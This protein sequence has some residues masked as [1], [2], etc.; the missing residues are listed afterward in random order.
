MTPP[1]LTR[2]V[3]SDGAP[4]RNP[5]PCS[6]T[7]TGSG[8]PPGFPGATTSSFRQSSSADPGPRP[9]GCGHGLPGS[10]ARSVDVQPACGT[11]GAHRRS[12]RGAAAY[13]MPRQARTPSPAVPHTA[14]LSVWTVVPSAQAGAFAPR[15]AAGNGADT[16]IG[17]AS[18]SAAAPAGATAKNPLLRRIPPL[19]TASSDAR[20]E[21][22]TVRK[23][24]T[25]RS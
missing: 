1:S 16:P 25:G 24:V 4:S 6:S 2:C 18:A 20:P 17:T 15:A 23:T 22:R 11:G 12:P 14:P 8:F 5:P 9:G 3:P 10:V 13:G 21:R 19:L 7:I